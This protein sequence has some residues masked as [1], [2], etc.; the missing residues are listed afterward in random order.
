MPLL[1][2]LAREQV[3]PYVDY[4]AA[5]IDDLSINDGDELIR[6]MLRV[7]DIYR[8]VM[9]EY[10]HF[11]NLKFAAMN[12]AKGCNVSTVEIQKVIREYNLFY[13]R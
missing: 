12:I 10:P 11:I 13:K 1:T 9:T 2:L 5:N 8:D 7:P 4:C 3:D 6:K